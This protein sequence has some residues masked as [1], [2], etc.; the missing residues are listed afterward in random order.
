ML[1]IIRFIKKLL[2][3]G[4]CNDTVDFESEYLIF[5]K[6]CNCVH[7]TRYQDIKYVTYTIVKNN[8]FFDIVLQNKNDC[9]TYKKLVYTGL[10]FNIFSINLKNFVDGCIQYDIALV[11]SLKIC[12][13][14]FIDT[15]DYSIFA[16][17][18]LKKKGLLCITNA[19]KNSLTVYIG[20]FSWESININYSEIFEL[21]DSSIIQYEDI[22][23]RNLKRKDFNV[24]ILDKSFSLN[25]GYGLYPFL[26]NEMLVKEIFY[27]F[28]IG[29]IKAKIIEYFEKYIQ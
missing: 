5:R 11:P 7:K 10:R 12:H 14:P 28:N 23:S 15:M 27:S 24:M 6:Q 22:T 25:R 20:C 9:E 8:C 18:F 21:L 3:C 19:T 26:N 4:I 13:I 2:S 17:V 1:L 29:E 16:Q